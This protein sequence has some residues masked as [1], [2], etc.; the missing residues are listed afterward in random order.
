MFEV[1]G[2][3]YL[4]VKEIA[5]AFMVLFAVIDITGSVPVIINLNASG[6]RV[7]SAAAAVISFAVIILFLFA[8]E[9]M[10][11]LF[12]VDISSFAIAGSIVLFILAVEMLLGVEIFKNEG[13]GSNATIIPVVFPL[14]AG[15]GVLTTT[16]S[17][18]SEV[19][20]LNLIIAIALNMLLV[21]VVLRN[22]RFFER[23][24][25]QGGIFVLRKFFGVILLAMAVRLFVSNLTTLI[26]N[27]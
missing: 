27:I 26:Q 4:S 16:L 22:L 7:N 23:V 13:P 9:A 8:G 3:F 1:M 15:A 12:N 19:H 18:R 11:K 2:E 24:L 17:L 10:L 21:Y 5:T 20:M 25:G 14:V 6:K